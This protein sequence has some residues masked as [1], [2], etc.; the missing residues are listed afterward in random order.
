M[1]KYHVS[2]WMNLSGDN[3]EFVALRNEALHQLSG[4]P[5]PHRSVWES[6][7]KSKLEHSHSSA[8]LEIC[9]HDLFKKRGWKIEIEPDLPATKNKP[10]FLLSSGSRRLMVEAR[11]VLGTESERQQDDRLKRL[12]N[13]L[14]GKLDRTVLIHPLFELPSSL[15]NKHLAAQIESK[16]SEVGL[17]QEF[18]VEGEHQGQ[19]YSL[20]VTVLLETK[21]NESGDVGATI[22]QAVEFDIG[23]SVREAIIG[24]AH[25]YGE[26]LIPYVI[27]VWPKLPNHFSFEDDDDM[28]A[29]YGDETWVMSG[30]E[31]IRSRKLN[32]VFTLKR[33]DSSYRYSDIS[34]V[35][36]CHP[37]NTDS[38]KIYVHH[39]PFAKRPVGMEMFKGIPQC[40]IDLATGQAQ[41]SD[42]Y[43]A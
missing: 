25:K 26:M 21:P 39:N 20:E 9:L 17:L 43:H 34:A 18:L 4:V 14:R 40:S 33:E 12:M 15:P 27:A 28:V 36:F 38:F 41:W 2:N 37:Y 24:K 31:I 3:P 1:T 8:R 23:N 10:D 22:N 32:G 16:A 30:A 19:P 42:S 7:L 6:R 11:A 35:F 29:L 5:E 13:D